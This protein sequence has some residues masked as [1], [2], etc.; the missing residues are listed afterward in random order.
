L[1]VANQAWGRPVNSP[2]SFSNISIRYGK[3]II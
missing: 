3:P 1:P 2:N